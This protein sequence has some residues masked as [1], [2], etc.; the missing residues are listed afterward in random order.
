[1][2]SAWV[3]F[4]LAESALML[5][6]SGDPAT[7]LETGIRQHINKVVGFYP[8]GS[9][10]QADI[11][12]YVTDVMTD[13]AAADQS[14]KLDIIAREWYIS[15]WGNAIEPFNTYRRTGF[16]SMMMDP[17]FNLGPFMRSFLYAEDETSTNTNPDF[18]QR[19]ILDPVF[20]DN[21]PDGF[22]N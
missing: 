5:G 8:A 12:A 22:I 21:N 13:F 14:G 19:S 7:Y 2:L 17:V 11:D 4:M 16:P 6:T 18:V 1:M 15:S 9:P 10:D 20:W 3:Q